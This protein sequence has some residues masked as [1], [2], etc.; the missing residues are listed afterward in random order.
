MHRDGCGAEKPGSWLYEHGDQFQI[1]RIKDGVTR[2]KATRGEANPVRRRKVEPMES[3]E[4]EGHR[5]TLGE[6]TREQRDIFEK[7]GMTLPGSS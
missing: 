7:L 6:I 2:W 4:R 3:F 5:P 1:G